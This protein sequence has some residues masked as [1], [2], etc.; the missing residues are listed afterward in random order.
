[1][2]YKVT[3]PFT[4]KQFDKTKSAKY[5]GDLEF[6]SNKHGVIFDWKIN[7]KEIYIDLFT[8]KSWFI[9]KYPQFKIR[10]KIF[11]ELNLKQE[12][13]P[14][15]SSNKILKLNNFQVQKINQFFNNRKK[16]HSTIKTIVGILKGNNPGGE[17]KKPSSAELIIDS[18]S[19]IKNF[20][21]LIDDLIMKEKLNEMTQF[22]LASIGAKEIKLKDFIKLNEELKNAFN[23][24]QQEKNEN[25]FKTYL[26]NIKEYY[27]K[28][29]DNIK[30]VERIVKK[31]RSKY[32]KN[33]DKNINNFPFQ[34]K[35][36]SQFQK[37]HIY[38]INKIKEQMIYK[39]HENKSIEKYKLMISDPQNFLPLTEEIHRKFDANY[40][41]YKLDGTIWPI[42]EEG[43]L[44]V[45]EELDNKYKKIDSFF[46]NK[47]R[48]KYLEFRNENLIF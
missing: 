24:M 17:A 27:K 11:K 33:I 8:T 29:N 1:M 10:E 14:T 26:E 30:Q 43:F 35:N 4:R 7:F 25:D 5:K 39:L 13:R 21:I 32:S 3:I 31:E 6:I 16:Y 23:F 46:L 37:C 15:N 45:K 36:K 9:K 44:F 47:D 28:Y 20:I 19:N 22:K 2:R 40:F 48:K 12:V 34:F 38:E 42:H 41:T 18:S